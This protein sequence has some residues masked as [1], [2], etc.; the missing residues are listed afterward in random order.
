MTICRVGDRIVLEGDCY[1]EEAETL[2][3]LLEDAQIVD[4]SKCRYL[5]S[6]VLQVLLSFRPAIIGVP[7]DVFLANWISTAL[8]PQD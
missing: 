2:M 8:A 4:W 7:E 3:G 6:A 1:L 5:H